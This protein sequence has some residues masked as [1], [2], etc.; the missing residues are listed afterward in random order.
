MLWE[1]LTRTLRN[2]DARS[3]IAPERYEIKFQ[4]DEAERRAFNWLAGAIERAIPEIWTGEME[5]LIAKEKEW[6]MSRPK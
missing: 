1:A 4:V 5:E 3:E 6:I 2:P